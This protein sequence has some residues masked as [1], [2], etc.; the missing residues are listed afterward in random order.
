MSDFMAF[1][2]QAGALSDSLWIISY[3]FYLQHHQIVA[4][5]TSNQTY[6][7][8]CGVIALHTVE[9]IEMVQ[10]LQIDCSMN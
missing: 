1:A 5:F 3:T 6:A 10:N 9:S 2:G 4:Y 8:H 7:V